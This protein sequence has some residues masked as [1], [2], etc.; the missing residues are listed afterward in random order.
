MS[1][2]NTIYQKLSPNH[3]TDQERR[4][5]IKSLQ[6]IL[7]TTHRLQQEFGPS[8]CHNVQAHPAVMDFIQMQTE[9]QVALRALMPSNMSQKEYNH[10][11]KSENPRV[12]VTNC[13]V[14]PEVVGLT[15]QIIKT[16]QLASD[17]VPVHLVMFYKN[18]RGEGGLVLHLSQNQIK[19]ER[20]GR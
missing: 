16:R 11:S 15:G 19:L 2:T 3:I 7:E 12:T 4:D 8:D 6:S 5:I 18:N 13:K 14:T 10:Y 1:Q 17:P 9:A 20:E